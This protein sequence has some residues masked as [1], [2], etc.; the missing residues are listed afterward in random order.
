[1]VG[2]LQW[3]V[4]VLLGVAVF[5]VQVAAFADA[6]S[7]PRNAFTSEGKLTKQIWLLILGVA[8][9]LGFLGLPPMMWTSYSFLNLFALV[10]AVVYWVDVR[11]RVR[12]YR[13]RKGPSGPQYPG[14]W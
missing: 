11:P 5:A 10:P 13:R 7:E 12:P 1:M 6:V 8:M 9:A 14:R 3:W 4:L 2:N